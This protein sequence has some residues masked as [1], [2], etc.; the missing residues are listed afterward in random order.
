[1][2]QLFQDN[3][4]NDDENEN[5]NDESYDTD[6][7]R[8]YLKIQRRKQQETMNIIGKIGWIEKHEAHKFISL[9]EIQQF[10]EIFDL[11]FP[12]AKERILS[13]LIT[14]SKLFPASIFE[15]VLNYCM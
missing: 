15:I 14:M 2:E 5:E 10:Q 1:M 3:N 8:D 6:E 9:K 11:R 4:D 7:E 13:S 12:L